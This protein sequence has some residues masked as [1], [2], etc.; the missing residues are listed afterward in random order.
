MNTFTF[1]ATRADGQIVTGQLKATNQ[2][3]AL[4]VLNLKKLQP[5][6]IK[7]K[8]S[9][10]KL[11]SGSAVAQKDLVVFSRQLAFLVESG[12]PIIQS[13]QIVQPITQSAVLKNV[14]AQLIKSVDKGKNFSEALAE[15]PA[16]FNNLF[17][18]LVQAGESSGKLDTLLAQLA[19]DI[20]SSDNLRSKV[21]KAL[22]YPM[23]VLS[24]GVI[25]IIGLMVFVVPKF[26]SV[27]ES[28]GSELPAMTK[29]LMSVSDFFVNNLLFVLFIL[30]AA[31]VT[32][33]IY[34]FSPAGRK[35][36][37]QLFWILPIIGPIVR[38]NSLA[39]FTK[40]LSY[41]M[42]SGVN[43]T[44]SL[45]NA[46]AASNNYLVE[47]SIQ[48]AVASVE[49]GQS[50]A[51]SIAK[52][53]IFPDLLSHMISIGEETGKLDATLQKVSEF[54]EEQVKTAASAIADMIQPIFIVV[55]GGFVAFV[56]IAM[57]LPIFK[58]AGAAGGF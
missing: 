53:R 10:L 54:Y 6:F 57:Y 30:V 45:N 23:F 37:D 4:R 56:V 40:T 18:S 47:T 14:L 58:L 39:R 46:A 28:A 19:N 1:K 5:I 21:T 43:V 49:K 2:N 36:K 41:L 8:Q 29:I 50:I 7:K 34:L 42:A 9:M 27:F 15:H 51:Q 17:F 22:M 38:K 24:I 52:E 25:I 13:L 35:F 20:E 26:A 31:P 33:F 12:V 11:G 32:F 3:E 44:E 55:L 16:V 48:K